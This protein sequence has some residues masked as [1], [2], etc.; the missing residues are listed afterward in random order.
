QLRLLLFDPIQL[1]NGED[2]DCVDAHTLR[3]RDAHMAR[4]GMDAEMDV[5]DVLQD[6]VHLDVAEL[7]LRH[8]QYSPCALMIRKIRSTSASSRRMSYNAALMTCSRAWTPRHPSGRTRLTV[9][10]SFSA[11]SN[12]GSPEAVYPAGAS[13]TRSARAGVPWAFFKLL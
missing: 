6:H 1:R 4:R 5:L 11:R 2:S 9:A 13:A 12:T 3:G 10:S 8:H 7:D